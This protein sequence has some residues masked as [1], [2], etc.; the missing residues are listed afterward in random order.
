MRRP[1]FP[2]ETTIPVNIGGTGS[3]SYSLHGTVGATYTLTDAVSVSVGPSGTTGSDTLTNH[4][5]GG[6][7]FGGT[8]AAVVTTSD[9][10]ADDINLSFS[11]S[12]AETLDETI[13]TTESG[14]VTT[15]SAS[16]TDTGT[17]TFDLSNS[18]AT[19][20]YT[21]DDSDSYDDPIG[22]S[23]TSASPSALAP[24]AATSGL[25]PAG[26]PGD[27]SS[28]KRT[29]TPP[30][31]YES[32][33]W[34]AVSGFFGNLWDRATYVP[35]T[36]WANTGGSDSS[37]AGRIYVTAG[38]T[39]GSLVGVTQVSDAFAQHDA[40]D[41][42]EQTTSE[43]VFKGVSGTV[44][45][46]TLGASA[47]GKLT[48]SIAPTKISAQAPVVAGRARI[49]WQYGRTPPGAA[50]MTDKFGNITIRP[51]L[52]GKELWETVRHESVHR[53]FSPKSGP[54]RKLRANLGYFGYGKSQLIRYT[55]EAIAETVATRS[56]L[57][58]LSF[59]TV[60]YQLSLTRT[61]AEGL[62]YF[63]VVVGVPYLSYSLFGD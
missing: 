35:K 41:G 47:A 56:L 45:L 44:Q 10:T 53:F 13:T 5:T 37:L 20:N 42:H 39:A 2:P 62:G 15:P 63:T 60:G 31:G 28:M 30:G 18:D 4:V 25:Q 59:P 12:D 7:S 38:T 14:G 29:G 11:G 54:F 23:G 51:G 17:D 16:G 32:P 36:V 26:A 24:N 43:R 6:D 48:T 33:T 61:V 49:P 27:T 50:G 21:E 40:V 19:N 3:D 58:G 1:C 34:S 55:E 8:D 57:K 52:A 22:G 9:G 46:A